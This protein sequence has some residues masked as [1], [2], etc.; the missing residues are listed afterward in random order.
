MNLKY[1]EKKVNN[2]TVYEWYGVMSWLGGLKFVFNP[3]AK[4]ITITCFDPVAG[5]KRVEEVY[6]YSEFTGKVDVE[7]VYESKQGSFSDNVDLFFSGLDERTSNAQFVM[8]ANMMPV[9]TS[10]DHLLVTLHF[11]N[12]RTVSFRHYACADV[13]ED[14]DIINERVENLTA[15]IEFLCKETGVKSPFKQKK[16]KK[17]ETEM[18]VV[19]VLREYKKLL[20]DG[21][22]TQEQFNRKRDELMN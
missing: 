14:K 16:E 8:Q 6:K 11:T 13:N 20:D 18:D 19:R 21:I 3:E 7:T 4:T 12:N 10:L 5:M 17:P 2:H 15:F 1:R 9:Y 22:I